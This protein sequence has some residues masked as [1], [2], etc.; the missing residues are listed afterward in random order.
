[1]ALLR[2]ERNARVGRCVGRPGAPKKQPM[3]YRQYY[4]E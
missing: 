4:D 3:S 2:A 1:M